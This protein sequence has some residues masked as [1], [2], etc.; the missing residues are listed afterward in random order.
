[1]KYCTKCG[2]ELFDEA[3]MCPNCGCMVQGHNSFSKKIK[4]KRNIPEKKENMKLELIFSFVSDILFAIGFFLVLNALC[5][6]WLYI[7]GNNYN[8]YHYGYLYFDETLLILSIIFSGLNVVFNIVSLI[9][10]LCSDKE[11]TLESTLKFISRLVIA[12]LLCLT[13]VFFATTQF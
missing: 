5:N 7:G 10:Y 4:A 13:S 2:K 3:I 9:L 6:P 8:G 12:I 1:M 11:K